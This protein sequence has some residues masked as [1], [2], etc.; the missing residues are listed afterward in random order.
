[1]V[2]DFDMKKSKIQFEWDK[3]ADAWVDF[4]RTGK[5]H[6]RYY[7]NNP[8]IFRILG[9]IRNKKVLD[10][11]CGEGYNSRIMAK[12]GG[13]VIGI[14]FSEKMIEFARQQEKKDKLGIKY[15]ICNTTNLAIFKNNT[16][17]ITTSF[18]SIQDIKNYKGALKEAYRVLKKDGRIVIGT[19]HPCFEKTIYR[20]GKYYRDEQYFKNR[21]YTLYWK[22]KRLTKHFITTGFHRTLTEYANTLF[23]TGFV[24]S[25]LLEPKP[26]KKGLKVHPN[27]KEQLIFPQSIVIEAIKR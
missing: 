26:T 25:R 13:I 24:I 15:Y 19:T 5:D 14:D 10:L 6:C 22:M 2:L 18:M 12:K 20:D 11:G 1:M 8:G 17:N 7:M 9:S 27:L 23:K 21:A 3:S 4:V 16:F